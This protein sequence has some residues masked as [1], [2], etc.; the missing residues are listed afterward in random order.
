MRIRTDKRKIVSN[1]GQTT[2]KAKSGRTAGESG[3]TGVA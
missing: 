1:E 3:E 2:A